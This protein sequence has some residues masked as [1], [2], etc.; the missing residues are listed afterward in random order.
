[1]WRRQPR[2]IRSPRPCRSGNAL[3]E[4]RPLSGQTGLSS[5]IMMTDRTYWLAEAE[6][7]FCDVMRALI[8]LVI[9][10]GT[11]CTEQPKPPIAVG[12]PIAGFMV[13]FNFDS[14]GLSPPA[15]GTLDQV[16]A[17]AAS[18][19]ADRKLSVCGHADSVGPSEA[20]MA[21]SLRRADAVKQ[22]LVERGVA[23]DRIVAKGYGDSQPMVGAKPGVREPQ[24]RRAVIDI[25][26]VQ[27][28]RYSAP[29]DPR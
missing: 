5:E 6:H 25:E 16:T 26:G 12:D 18:K 21:V 22:A 11:A 8:T 28:M 15:L 1:M 24:N 13:F 4:G 10:V 23:P 7:C 17:V 20:N 27:G 14:S 19:G 3:L 9:L 2:I 29:C